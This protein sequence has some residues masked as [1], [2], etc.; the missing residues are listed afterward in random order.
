MPAPNTP[1][2]FF[3]ALKTGRHKA[4]EELSI[5]CFLNA[6]AFLFLLLL[7]LNTTTVPGMQKVLNKHLL[8]PV[9]E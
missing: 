5:T 7:N 9:S 1:Y 3:R 2:P 6:V 4:R 8:E